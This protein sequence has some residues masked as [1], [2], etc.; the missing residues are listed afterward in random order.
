MSDCW[1]KSLLFGNEP[2]LIFDDFYQVLKILTDELIGEFGLEKGIVLLV[3]KALP[4]A[5]DLY[6]YVD[7]VLD[8]YSVCKFRYV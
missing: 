7:C 4:L 5:C 2:K 6:R 1:L 3:P 8:L